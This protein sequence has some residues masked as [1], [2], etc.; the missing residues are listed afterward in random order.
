MGARSYGIIDGSQALA[1]GT[2]LSTPSIKRTTAEAKHSRGIIVV[3][4]EMHR[5]K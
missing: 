4:V 3:V 1:K 5:Q 2:Q